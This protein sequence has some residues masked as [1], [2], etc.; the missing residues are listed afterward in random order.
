MVGAAGVRVTAATVVAP[1]IDRAV[2]VARS[3]VREVKP[4]SFG[5]AARGAAAR[6]VATEKMEEDS[7][8]FD[9]ATA[10]GDGFG[11][12]TADGDGLDVATAD[13][14]AAEA[15]DGFDAARDAGFDPVTTPGLGTAGFPLGALLGSG[16][17]TG[18]SW[19][20]A[21]P[22]VWPEQLHDAGLE[23]RKKGAC[24]PA[25]SV[26]SH[27]CM[28]PIWGRC[29]DP[30]FVPPGCRHGY[31]RHPIWLPLSAPDQPV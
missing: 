8:G 24:A 9:P 22:T 26:S 1:A 6:G 19:T 25:R 29:R 11:A 15:G 23:P 17:S 31:R 5:V 3:G 20:M 16:L 28:V 4:T 13:G 12:A 21:G 18:R 10:V 14:F 2:A 7:D 30:A 27:R